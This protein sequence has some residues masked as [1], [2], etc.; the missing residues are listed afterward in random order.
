MFEP[1]DP[2]VRFL[3]GHARRTFYLKPWNG[4]CGDT[5]IW[6]GTEHLFRDLGI[7]RTLDP[8]AADII[9]IPGGNQ[10]MWQA[11]IDLWNEVRSKY[12]DKG[13]AVGPVTVRLGVTTWQQDLKAAGARVLGIFARD[14]ESYA[15]LLAAGLDAGITVGLSHDPSLYLRHSPLLREH[16]EAATSEF[17]LAAFRHDWEGSGSPIPRLGTWPRRLLPGLLDRIDRRWR[18]RAR[19]RKIALVDR[20][21]RSRLPLKVCDAGQFPLDYFIEIVRAAAEVHTDRLHAMLL[22]VMLGKTTFA[23]PTAYAKLEAVYQHSLKDWACVEFVH[24]ARPPARG[25]DVRAAPAAS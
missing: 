12:P 16:R 2:Y 8:R 11:N 19:R 20:H 24:E 4:N 5:L 21:R 15:N 22:A 18:L 9:L 6:L 10:T 17:V 13:F 7:R 1:D 14:R 3:T 23:Y 25:A